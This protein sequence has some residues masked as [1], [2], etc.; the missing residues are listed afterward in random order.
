MKKLIAGLVLSLGLILPVTYV[1]APAAETA[2]TTV[3]SAELEEAIAANNAA[4]EKVVAVNTAIVDM[5][6]AKQCDDEAIYEQYCRASE[7]AQYAAAIAKIAEFDVL[8]GDEADAIKN[9]NKS[10]KLL[11]IAE[12]RLLEVLTLLKAYEPKPVTPDV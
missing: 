12:A 2:V 6:N 5:A 10:M 3:V 7:P 9:L 1:T 4:G 11:G 8:A